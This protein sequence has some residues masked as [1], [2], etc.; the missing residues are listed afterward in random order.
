MSTADALAAASG[1]DVAVGELDLRLADPAGWLGADDAP[2]M[3]TF[4]SMPLRGQG[5]RVVGLVALSSGQPNAFGETA[6][7][8]LRLVDGPA[9][10]VIDNARLAGIR[11]A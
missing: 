8:T 10:I 2:G 1:L 3:A 9:A 11:T 6:L 4:L 7:A 5:G